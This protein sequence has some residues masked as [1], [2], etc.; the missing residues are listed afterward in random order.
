MS[1]LEVWYYRVDADDLID[2]APCARSRSRREKMARK[3]RERVGENLFPKITQEVD[4]RHH[5]VEQPHV[6]RRLSDDRWQAWIR[7]ALDCYRRSLPE[8]RRLLL[9]RFWLED[10]ALRVVGIGSVATRC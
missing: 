6:L 2:M 10:F 4:G 8:D 3:A 7:A 9:D 1:P 5:F